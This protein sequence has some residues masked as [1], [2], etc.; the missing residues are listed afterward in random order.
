[1]RFFIDGEWN[2]WRPDDNHVSDLISLALVPE[3]PKLKSFYFENEAIDSLYVVPWVYDNVLPQL[4][5]ANRFRM[6]LANAQYAMGHYL[7]EFKEITIIADWPEDIERF[8]RF[9]ITGPGERI[10]TPPLKFELI[11]FGTL[12]VNVV[13]ERPHNALF[14]AIANRESYV[15]S[16]PKG[17]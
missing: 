2:G 15:R 13:S 8:C 3:D 4:L 11:D 5:G 17:E 1:M 6:S 9:L 14:D 12:K 10:P 7:F 16:L